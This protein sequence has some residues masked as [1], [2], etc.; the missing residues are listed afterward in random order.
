MNYEA[1]YS[2]LIERARGRLISGC[3]ERHHVLPRCIGGGNEKE[4]IVSLTPEEHY[5]AHQLLVKMYPKERGLLY[6]AIFMAKHSP[7]NKTFGWLRRRFIDSQKGNKHALG[8]KRPPETRARMSAAQKGNKKGRANLGKPKSQSQ[9]EKQSSV[10]RGRKPTDQA[11][12][13][14]SVAG[15]GKTKSAEHRANISRGLRAFHDAP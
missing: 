13:K 9:K 4:N 15:R 6:A 5:V 2:S 11:R 10:M 12:Q 1:H 8:I 14:M 7:N 3:I